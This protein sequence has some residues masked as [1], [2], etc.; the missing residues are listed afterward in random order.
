MTTTLVLLLL[1]AAAGAVVRRLNANHRR[2]TA[3]PTSDDLTDRDVARARSDLAAARS[4]SVS[5][6]ARPRVVRE[7]SV[8]RRIAPPTARAA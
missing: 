5:G 4:A 6:A 8:G 2:V 7:A 1:A 3:W